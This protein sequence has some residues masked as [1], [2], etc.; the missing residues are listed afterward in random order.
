MTYEWVKGSE[1]Y[2]DAQVAGEVIRSIRLRSGGITP[3]LLIEESRPAVAP[4]HSC[5]E[6]DDAAAAV[7][8]RREQA[9]TVI[10]SIKIVKDEK[11]SERAKPVR[12]AESI[13]D[14]GKVVKIGSESH[15]R[16][17]IVASTMEQLAKIKDRLSAI[18][19]LEEAI[20]ILIDLQNELEDFQ[21]KESRRSRVA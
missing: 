1:I 4:L 21:D 2:V 12:V 14:S 10:N 18:D 11:P 16:R 20:A 13:P 8:Y 15:H 5:F 3:D 19:G 7:E 17:Y 6:W 9:R